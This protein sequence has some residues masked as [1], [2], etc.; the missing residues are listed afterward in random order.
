MYAQYVQTLCGDGQAN[1]LFGF[2]GCDMNQIPVSPG[3]GLYFG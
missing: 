3:T 1:I 2:D